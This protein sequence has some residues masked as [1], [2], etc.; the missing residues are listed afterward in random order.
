M[1]SNPL[2]MQKTWVQSLCQEDPLGKGMAIHS[3]TLAWII[4]WAEKPAG[5]GPG[6]GKESDV[7]ER[8]ST[9]ACPHPTPSS[10][11]ISFLWD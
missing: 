6:D 7:T 2:A 11:I 8:L 5:Y 3:S 4:P 9:Q 10:D 1:V